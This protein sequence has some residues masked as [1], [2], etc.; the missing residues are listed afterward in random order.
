MPGFDLKK[1]SYTTETRADLMFRRQELL[2]K[3]SV[4]DSVEIREDLDDCNSKLAKILPASTQLTSTTSLG[5]RR[6]KA[7]SRKHSVA[8]Y[9]LSP[10]LQRLTESTPQLP[11]YAGIMTRLRGP[12]HTRTLAFHLHPNDS[13]MEPEEMF[14]AESTGR[15]YTHAG[16]AVSLDIPETKE[17]DKRMYK[18]DLQLEGGSKKQ[19]WTLPKNFPQEITERLQS[20]NKR[21]T[22][23]PLKERLKFKP[24]PIDQEDYKALRSFC[25]STEPNVLARSDYEPD[26]EVN[27]NIPLHLVAWLG[28]EELLEKFLQWA[29]YLGKDYVNARNYYEATPLHVGT[30]ELSTA[31]FTMLLDYGADVNATNHHKE[32]V[33]DLVLYK[34]DG[35]R[36]RLLL[37]RGT[38][39]KG[40]VGK[41]RKILG[42][43]YVTKLLEARAAR[44]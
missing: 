34:E 38:D 30:Y 2:L 14:L 12:F 8:D 37:E 16:T 24:D 5:E 26:P 27:R 13:S 20:L 17:H 42:R 25:S 36:L 11:H 7:T 18:G 41:L 4:Y 40:K 19:M 39:P 31:G 28:L 1:E 33:L 43:K 10:E 32:S 21:I 9:H 23:G 22:L 3:I 29:P 15:R 6:K 35:E 44:S